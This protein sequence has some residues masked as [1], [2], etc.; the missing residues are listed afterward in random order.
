[1][2]KIPTTPNYGEYQRLFNRKPQV[3]L[4]QNSRIPIKTEPF[5]TKLP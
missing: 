4:W 2:T 1:M 5:K 3:A